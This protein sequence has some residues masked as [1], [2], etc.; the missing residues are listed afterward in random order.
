MLVSRHEVSMPNQP[1][2]EADRRAIEALNQQDIKAVMASDIAT[3]TSQW[4]DDFVVLPSAGPIVRGR[5]ANVEMVEQAKEQSGFRIL[6]SG[7]I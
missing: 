3:I 4:T 5:K 7:R 6:T 1:S 2:L